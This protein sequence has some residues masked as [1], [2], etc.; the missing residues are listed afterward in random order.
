MIGIRHTYFYTYRS[1]LKIG[2]AYTMK[3]YV[4]KRADRVYQLIYTIERDSKAKAT[5][6]DVCCLASANTI[7]NL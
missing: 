4:S 5:L 7:T 6:A 3:I 2:D 1:V